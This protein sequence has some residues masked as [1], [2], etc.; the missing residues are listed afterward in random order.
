[1]KG[2][3]ETRVFFFGLREAPMIPPDGNQL[4]C[5]QVAVGRPRELE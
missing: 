1:M 5:R 3:A 4:A 2:L